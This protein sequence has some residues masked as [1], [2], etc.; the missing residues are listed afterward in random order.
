MAR[1]RPGKDTDRENGRPNGAGRARRLLTVVVAATALVAS[2]SAP[3]WRRR[4]PRRRLRRSRSRVPGS[5]M[6]S[7]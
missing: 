7:G 4:T 2:T 1:H 3:R 6:V 5:D